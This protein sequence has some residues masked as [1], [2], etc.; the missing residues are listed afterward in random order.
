VKLFISYSSSIALILPF[1]FRRFP[2][3][4]DVEF[5]IDK[6]SFGAELNNIGSSLAV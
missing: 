2:P 6:F 4:H 3:V 5:L 1:T